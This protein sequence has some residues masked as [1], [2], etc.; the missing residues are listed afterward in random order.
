MSPTM[1]TPW[2]SRSNSSTSAMPSSDGDERA[3]DGRRDPPQPEH[4]RE[5]AGAD[6]E[7]QRVGLAEVADDVP[8]LLEEVALAV[9]DPQQLR[10]LADDDREREPDD[11]A[12]QHRLGDERREEAEPQEAG[13]QRR[14]RPTHER[15][16]DGE[17]RRR[18]RCPAGD[19]RRPSPPTAPRWPPS[20]RP[21]GGA[22][23]RARRRGQRARARRRGR[24]R[25]DAGDR[26]VGQRLRDEHGPDRQPGDQ[27]PPQTVAHG[28]ESVEPPGDP[29]SPRASERRLDDHRRDRG[30]HARPV[31]RLALELERPA[32]RLDA[33]AQAL[34]AGA[35]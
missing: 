24:R 5:R 2:S 28:A 26:G 19:I 23:C 16:R 17:L 11:E 18:R 33:I 12:L 14:R 15:E 8:E 1:S 13:E 6:R 29:A 22:S 32:D 9:V 25:G 3:R 21:R 4:E 30:A 31:A 7:R 35:R 27:V 10:H 34:E 20:G